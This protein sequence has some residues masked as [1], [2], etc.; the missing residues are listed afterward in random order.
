[1]KKI[2]ISFG[3]EVSEQEFEKV[4]DSII[5][6]KNAIKE[7][8]VEEKPELPL[9]INHY[10][11]KIAERHNVPT[12]AIGIWLNLVKEIYP[13]TFFATILR[14]IALELDKRYEDHISNSE[15]LYSISILNGEICKVNKAK[16]KSYKN[17][18]AFRNIADAKFACKVL[19]DEIKKLFSDGSKQED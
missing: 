11:D 3:P 1:M 2:V 12:C 4:L 5:N 17:F 8:E 7:P 10:I 18:A 6:I 14:E 16:I 15:E 13:I 19:R 9:D